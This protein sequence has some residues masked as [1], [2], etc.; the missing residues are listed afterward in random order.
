[1]TNRSYV[2]FYPSVELGGAEILF[3]RLADQLAGR[4]NDVTVLDSENHV[5]IKNLTN[6]SVKKIVV[7]HGSPELISC[8]YII[9]FASNIANISKYINSESFG[10]LLFW[11]VHPF[12]NIYLPPIVGPKLVH[13]GLGW[14]K[15]VNNLLFNS[16]DKVRKAALQALL[17][18]NAF[19]CMDG[20]NANIINNYYNINAKF[21]FIPIPVYLKEYPSDHAIKPAEPISLFWYGRLCDFKSHSLVYL[22]EQI[23][24]LEESSSV[25]RLTVI[26]DGPYRSFIEKVATQRG[27]AIS[28]VGALPNSESIALLKDKADAV[29]A[30]GTAALESGVLGIPTILAGASFGRINFDYKFDWLYNTSHFTLGV[31]LKKES[32][33][34]GISFFELIH[35]LQKNSKS[36]AYRCQ[37]YVTNNHNIDHIVDLVEQHAT[38]SK[39]DFKSFS[40]IIRYKRPILNRIAACGRRQLALITNNC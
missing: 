28:F 37:Q 26:G 12:N 15:A 35:E 34:T 7:K 1:M 5:I 8:D 33:S 24:K 11:N 17:H 22:I 30:M 21:D 20:E 36:H 27:V 29:F 23:S 32:E 16:E 31:F 39:M 38:L 2:I 25:V 40:N 3:T 19:V 9:A 10:K 4:G 14:L 6:N 18:A 13:F